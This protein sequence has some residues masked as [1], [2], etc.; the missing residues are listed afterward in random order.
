MKENTIETQRQP[1]DIFN[2]LKKLRENS[3][4]LAT[5]FRKITNNQEEQIDEEVFD[6]ILLFLDLVQELDDLEFKNRLLS[7][8]AEHMRKS[9]LT[10]TQE[11]L[12]ISLSDTFTNLDNKIKDFLAKEEGG[13]VANLKN[14]VQNKKIEFLVKDTLG[15]NG[16]PIP[17][18]NMLNRIL[19]LINDIH[20]PLYLL[21]TVRE[22]FSNSE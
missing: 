12:L 17:S 7:I 19:D 20:T 14:I 1:E 16:R 10:E 9:G 8:F 13:T 11:S 6:K 21:E 5:F 18:Q 4:E 22:G 2:T 3:N 15:T